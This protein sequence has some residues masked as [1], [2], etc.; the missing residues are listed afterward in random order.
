M[1]TVR[2]KS[3]SVL[4]FMRGPIASVA[5]DTTTRTY[6]RC[7]RRVSDPNV[8]LRDRSI[9]LRVGLGRALPAEVLRHRA[10]HQR[11]EV[12]LVAEREQRP[13]PRRLQRRRLVL[14]ELPARPRARARVEVDDGVL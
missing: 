2:R 1:T 5:P 12:G 8:A 13:L 7:A 14:R 3:D 6:R 4:R 11:R 10:P 9:E